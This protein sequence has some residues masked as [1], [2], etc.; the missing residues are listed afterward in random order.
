LPVFCTVI[1]IMLSLLAEIVTVIIDKV[2]FIKCIL[3]FFTHAFRL[4]TANKII[5]VIAKY[6]VR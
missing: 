2:F 4:L 5:D 3:K 6:I 1:P